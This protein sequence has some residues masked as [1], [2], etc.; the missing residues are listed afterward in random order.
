MNWL[1]E[2]IIKNADNIIKEKVEPANQYVLVDSQII[3]Y[4]V[5]NLALMEE[6]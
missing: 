6:E 5:L 2:S 4:I 1:M 3:Y